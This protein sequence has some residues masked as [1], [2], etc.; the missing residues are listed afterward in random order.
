MDHCTEVYEATEE[1]SEHHKPTHGLFYSN[2]IVDFLQPKA[3]E[4][5]ILP[6]E[7]G[8]T[9]FAEALFCQVDGND[10]ISQ[11]LAENHFPSISEQRSM[12]E[13]VDQT[14]SFTSLVP[15]ASSSSPSVSARQANFNLNKEKQVTRITTDAKIKSRDI[16]QQQG[17]ECYHQVWMDLDSMTV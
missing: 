10:S 3:L 4:S 11:D 12:F 7:D 17:T 14:F 15:P 6:P 8:N 16:Y 13:R 1:F 5:P 9:P 2:Q